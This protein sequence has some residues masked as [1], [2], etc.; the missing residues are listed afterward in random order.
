MENV[1]DLI[2]SSDTQPEVAAKNIDR[3]RLFDM[4]P[5]AYKEVAKDYEQEAEALEVPEIEA[6]SGVAEYMRQSDQH[7]SLVKEDVE[8]LNYMEK[9]ARHYHEQTGVREPAGLEEN[10]EDNYFDRYINFA[11][12]TISDIPSNQREINKIIEKEFTGEEITENEKLKLSVLRDESKDLLNKD[13]GIDGSLEQLPVHIT[14]ALGEMWRGAEDNKALIA[15]IIGGT[16]VATTVPTLLVPVPLARVVGA[17]TGFVKGAT[18]AALTVGFLDGYKQMRNSV[19]NEL[20]IAGTPIQ[21]PLLEGEA[22]N[23]PLNMPRSTKLAASVGVGFIG[24][25]ASGILGKVLVGKNP[26]MQKFASPK[27]AAKMITNPAYGAKIKILGNIVESI[28][29]GS[30]TGGISEFARIFAVELSKADASE[31]GFLNVL[32]KIA[33]VENLKRVKDA[34]VIGGA[35]AGLISTVTNAAGY[36]GLKKRYTDVNKKVGAALGPDQ[37]MVLH[38]DGTFSIEKVK[39]SKEPKS[40]PEKIQS[41]PDDI[42][43]VPQNN[44]TLNE[45]VKVLD[46]Q[47]TI[48]NMAKVA[49]ASKVNKFAPAEMSN[50]KKKLF[51]VVGLNENVWLH[52]EDLQKFADDPEKATEV[53]NL[54]DPSGTLDQLDKSVPVRVPLTEMLPIIEKYPEFSDYMRMAPQKMNPKEGKNYVERLNEAPTKRQELMESLGVEG[55]MTPEQQTQVDRAL[56]PLFEAKEQFTDHDYYVKPTFTE[57]IES[58]LPVKV[59]DD[60]NN[61]QMETRIATHK[62]LIEESDAR[63]KTLENIIVKDVDSKDI[64][65]EIRLLDRELQVLDSFLDTKNLSEASKAITFKHKKKNFSA[66]AIDPDSLPALTDPENIFMDE[67]TRQAFIND[68]NIRKRKVFV[69]GGITLEES[70]AINGVGSGKEL[71]QILA[72]TP[73]RKQVK[74]TREQR[75]IELRNRVQ[76]NIKPAK[77]SARE[78]VLTNQTKV[79][80]K[81]LEFLGS[82]EIKT[83]IK[84]FKI[85]ALPVP[86]IE[87]LNNKAAAV[88]RK[89]KVGDINHNKYAVAERKNQRATVNHYGKNEIEQAFLAKENAAFNTELIRESMK[90]QD[91][92]KRNERFLKKLKDPKVIQELKDAKMFDAINEIIQVYKID[93]SRRGAVKRGKYNS[94]AKRLVKQGRGNF[95]VPDEYNDVREN[96]SEMTMEQFEAVTDLAQGIL[97]QARIENK[98]F[99]ELEKMKVLQTVEVAVEGSVSRLTKHPQWKLSRAVTPPKGSTTQWENAVDLTKSAASVLDTFESLVLELDEEIPGGY[100]SRLISKKLN[101]S[102]IQKLTDLDTIVTHL[103][104]VIDEFGR[105]DY[106]KLINETI[107]IPEFADFPTLTKNGWITKRDL[108]RMFVHKGHEGGLERLTNFRSRNNEKITLELIDEVLERE[109]TEREA[110]LAQN[111]YPNSIKPFEQRTVQLEKR[112][113]GRDV[114]LIKAIPIKHRGKIYPGGYYPAEAQSQSDSNKA[115]QALEAVTQA[116]D[117]FEKQFGMSNRENHS[118]HAASKMTNQ[119]RLKSRTGTKNPLNLGADHLNAMEAIVHDLAFREAGI[120]LFRIFANSRFTE[121]VKAVIG[122]KGY[123]VMYNNIIEKVGRLDEVNNNFF[124]EQHAIIEGGIRAFKTGHAVGVLAFKVSSVMVQFASL[125]TAMMRMGKNSHFHMS[126]AIY[127]ILTNPEYSLQIIELAN[128][129][130]PRMKF[131]KDGIDDTMV[132]S[133]RGSLPKSHAAI[134]NGWNKSANAI[135]TLRRGQDHVNEIG[136]SGMSAVDD[137]TKLVTTIASIKQFIA[138]DVESFPLSVQENM[139]EAQR[140]EAL[141]DYAQQISKNS[142]T[143]SSSTDKTAAEKIGLGKLFTNYWTD[144]RNSLTTKVS[145]LRKIRNSGKK[146]TRAAKRKEY[147][148][149]AKEAR[150]IMETFYRM[151]LYATAGALIIDSRSGEDTPITEALNAETPE[152][153]EETL[154]KTLV[155]IGKSVPNAILDETIGIRDIKYGTSS[156]RKTHYKAVSVPLFGAISDIATGF[157]GLADMLDDIMEFKIPSTP[158]R[159]QTK[160]LVMTASYAVGGIPF[161]GPR[162]FVQAM[163]S[164]VVDEVTNSI[165]NEA[166]RLYDTIDSF[167]LMFGDRPEAKDMIDDLVDVQKE[168]LPKYSGDTREVIPENAKE[169]LGEILSENRWDKLDSETGAAGVYQ[170]TEARWNEISESNPALALTENGRVSK[171]ISQQEKAMEWSIQDNTRGL[172]SLDIPVNLKTLYGTHRFGFDNYSEIHEGKINK[173]DPLFKGFTTVKQVKDFI[174]KQV[175]NVNN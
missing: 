64:A 88:V 67:E 75:K 39:Q 22:D 23:I 29:A 40:S 150:K 154:K 5:S 145:Q 152:D 11:K 70:A 78:D 128:K 106:Y 85:I 74:D 95:I 170:F 4:E 57:N 71:L 21:G 86:T 111:Y 36:K 25:I 93:T 103:N 157:S 7:T 118:E 96:M 46:V 12:N 58:K 119:D 8:V 159:T 98:L 80:L 49:T 24:G 153:Y 137:F 17:T 30:V 65:E 130:N 45:V 13:F 81:E 32:N 133:A 1:N 44:Q 66:S 165:S 53:R 62:M 107:N 90:A 63:F 124:R 34:V 52:I 10:K 61:A 122:P 121:N 54:I 41:L 166:G 35:T 33:T 79:H 126:S 99:K 114:T 164:M 16:M 51:S 105:D 101:D 131:N 148:E 87:A 163:N 6:T 173:N 100:H 43:D 162:E 169:S 15:T 146:L 160:G 135:A 55:E 174:A 117:N 120:D 168:V 38:E 104:K 92:I 136:M 47:D 27:L 113:T 59:I 28:G 112:T 108:M 123:G 2:E 172:L 82:N 109:L 129:V 42:P 175:K 83:Y 69:K 144:G 110:T 127:D 31:A 149:S 60:F 155:Y 73:T 141:S 48:N 77:M 72:T 97:H 56:N 156:K 89:T 167:K 171:N 125:P 161:S 20:S 68:P 102:D 116:K 151:V 138:G 14:S 134:F 158:S 140:F 9:Y 115:Q 91:V 18:T 143:S 76:Q 142:L 37:T 19:Y 26:I 50:I 139:T 132:K 3:A 147:R 94:L 84:G